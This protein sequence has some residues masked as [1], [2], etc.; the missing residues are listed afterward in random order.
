MTPLPLITT[1]ARSGALDRAWTLF[2]G[3]GYDAATGDPAA[4]AV[5]GR[6]LKDL[7]LR[8]SGQERADYLDRA[9]AAYAAADALDPQ[10]Y[11][12]INVA[13]LAA[14]GGDLDEARRV[15]RAVIARLDEPGWAETPYWL[16]ATWAEAMLIAGDAQAASAALAL[17]I[18]HDPD[19]WA[20]HA[21]TLRQ[22]GLLIPALGGETAWLDQHRPPRSMH[23][24]GHL[25]IDP[26][27]GAVL[28]AQVDA[29]L[30]EQRVG[31]GY[32]ALAAGSDIIIAEALIARG[33]ELQVILPNRVAD[34]VALSVRPFGEAWVARFEACLAA[35]AHVNEVTEVDSEF[36]PLAT[37]LAGD[38]AM[39]AA[40]LNARTLESQAIQLLV[41]DEGG[42]PY[43]DGASTARD[44]TIW[45]QAG[46]QQHVIAFP[47]NAPVAPSATVN[48]GRA[49]RPLL[50]LIHVGLEGVDSL[51]EGDF[52]RLNDTGIAPWLSHVATLSEQPD[53]AQPIGTA[54]LY[55]F[56]SIARAAHFAR[57]LHALDPPPGHPVRITG[58]YGLVHSHAATVYGPAIAGLLAVAAGA[59]P[60]AITLTEPFALSLSA[61]DPKAGRS[62][63]IGE[64]D[65]LGGGTMR[66]FGLKGGD[67]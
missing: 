24:V 12:L 61:H 13:S 36:E 15:A 19:G 41:I 1:L 7:A 9:R 28:R 14:L 46:G 51:G 64:H 42:G 4:L 21:S 20:D 2:R 43:G 18:T 35:A 3:G 60:G 48:E 39:G 40:L 23:Y 29:L 47:R 37:A 45:N 6:L 63:H 59:L 34:F 55:G 26:N 17:A 54:W 57:R 16:Q 10:P 30:S 31:F 50:A 22:F 62:E 27:D 58:H 52:A 5:K 8:A 67:V 25:G 66:L 44:G 49:D 56:A 65:L 38:I 11:L 33:A 53:F 32:G